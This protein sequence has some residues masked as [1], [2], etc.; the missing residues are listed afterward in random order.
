MRAPLTV[1]PEPPVDRPAGC[2][3]SPPS[4]ACELAAVQIVVDDAVP[5]QQVQHRTGEG[6]GG[7]GEEEGHMEG[8]AAATHI[9]PPIHLTRFWPPS[10]PPAPKLQADGQ[11][12]P[13]KAQF[14]AALD[15]RG[16]AQ[17]S[18]LQAFSL[19][20]HLRAQDSGGA[21]VVGALLLPDAP[22]ALTPLLGKRLCDGVPLS[23]ALQQQASPGQPGSAANPQVREHT[24]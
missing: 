20:L 23:L 19:T 22:L 8:A 11:W 2:G 12:Q 1:P 16:P 24:N 6:G 17:M 18:Q 13:L 21:A 14:L 9:H 3:P 10:S 15:R 4:G 7:G 5:Q